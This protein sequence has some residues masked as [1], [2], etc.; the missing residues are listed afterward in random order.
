M[1]KTYIMH[2]VDQ[3]SCPKCDKSVVLLAPSEWKWEPE[4]DP[5]FYVCWDCE[6]IGQVGI[7]PVKIVEEV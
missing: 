6:W 2:T 3:T 5:S 4:K 7:G 1:S